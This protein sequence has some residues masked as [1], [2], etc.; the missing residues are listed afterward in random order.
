MQKQVLPPQPCSPRMNT[1]SSAVPGWFPAGVK[2]QQAA[3][4]RMVMVPMGPPSAAS[5]KC[6]GGALEILPLP[7]SQSSS[8]IASCPGMGQ[9]SGS[10]SWLW[11]SAVGVGAELVP[12]HG[13]Y[14]GCESADLGLSPA[15]GTHICIA[16]VGGCPAPIL[17]IPRGGGGVG[18]Q[19]T[20]LPLPSI[21]EAVGSGGS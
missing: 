20:A 13:P 5:W 3:D 21:T 7:M 12:A 8:P 16:L 2:P 11:F 9:C 14:V 15:R 19:G 17:A 1:H 4:S 6:R 10:F 18:P